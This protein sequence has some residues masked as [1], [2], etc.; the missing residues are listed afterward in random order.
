MDAPDAY[1]DEGGGQGS[2]VVCV[3]GSLPALPRRADPPTQAT[4]YHVG[5][6]HRLFGS[7]Q[8]LREG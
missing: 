7:P 2:A 4:S 8:G 5:V 6:G 3:G 1:Q